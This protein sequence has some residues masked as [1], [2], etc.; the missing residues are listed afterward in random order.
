MIYVCLVVARV[1]PEAD[2]VPNELLREHREFRLECFR[3]L[4]EVG[5]L[6]LFKPTGSVYFGKI[7][8]AVLI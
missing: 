6:V 4:C 2:D 3:E 7:I 5:L 1:E 8:C